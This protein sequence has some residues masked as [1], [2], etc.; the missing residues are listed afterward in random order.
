M[1]KKWAALPKWMQI[2]FVLFLF[3]ILANFLHAFSEHWIAP[4]FLVSL[5]IWPGSVQPPRLVRWIPWIWIFSGLVTVVL[6]TSSFLGKNLLPP[7]ADAPTGLELWSSL[8][9]LPLLLWS[10][11]VR[12]NFFVPFLLLST[13]WASGL[14]FYL[15]INSGQ[16]VADFLKLS[17][18][19]C[20]EWILFF[21]L[22]KHFP[23]PRQNLPL[24][25]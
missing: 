20:S 16:E 2:F 5:I 6:L 25:Y 17:G 10:Y 14:S 4:I 3:S 1:K 21:Y 23:S 7:E 9:F 22:K 15:F 18:N 12:K 13:I 11:W 8:I 19:L 24:S